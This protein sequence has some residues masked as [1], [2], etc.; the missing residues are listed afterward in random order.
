MSNETIGYKS[1][2]KPVLDE[3]SYELRQPI[4]QKD[5]AKMASITPATMSHWMRP[6][7]VMRQL[8]FKTL[9]AITKA[10]NEYAE[11]IGRRYEP[12]QLIQIVGWERNKIEGLLL[13]A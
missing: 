13:P 4:Y 9:F 7:E 6:Y 11:K 10:V 1:L 8:D 3:I 12:E 5:I 2:L